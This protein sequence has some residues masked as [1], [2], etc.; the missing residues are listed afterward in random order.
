[1]KTE[2]SET[3]LLQG[4]LNLEQSAVNVSSLMESDFKSGIFW[5]SE[6]GSEL[7]W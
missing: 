4:R 5:D 2:I 7:P 6:T 3:A 1:V